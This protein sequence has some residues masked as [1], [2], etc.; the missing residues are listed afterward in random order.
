MNNIQL[1]VLDKIQKLA[2]NFVDDRAELTKLIGMWGNE[3]SVV[4]ETAELQE[5]PQFAHMTKAELTAAAGA[6]LAVST[7]LGEFNEANSN[8]VKLLK[9]VKG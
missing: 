1:N 8:V 7:A 6:L 2:L 9:I 3:F 4:P 5:I